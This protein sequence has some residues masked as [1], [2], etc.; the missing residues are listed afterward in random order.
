MWSCLLD[1]IVQKTLKLMDG[2]ITIT[3]SIMI[4]K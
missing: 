1:T 2:F 3:G 4:V